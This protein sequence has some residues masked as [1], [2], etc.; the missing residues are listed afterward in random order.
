MLTQKFSS[1][2]QSITISSMIRKVILLLVLMGIGVCSA[3]DVHYYKLTRIQ[4]DGTPNRNVSGGQF[5]TFSGPLCFESNS[6]GLSVGNGS[7]KKNAS[8]SNS[9]YTVYQGSSYWGSSTT[10][11]FNADKSVLNVV[12]DNG[13]IYVYK[14]AT[15]PAGVKTCSLIRKPSS[16]GGS[17]SGGYIPAGGQPPSTYTPQPTPNNNNPGRDNPSPRYVERTYTCTYCHGK[18]TVTDCD[19]SIPDFSGNGKY[20]SEC[21]RHVPMCHIHKRCPSC[22][23]KGTY[24][25][26][27]RAN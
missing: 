3:Q 5:I 21:G 10:F 22:G 8:Y 20:C 2:R 16:N 17:S 7:L 15:P 26:M 25:K 27:E 24:T 12:L 13:D 11:K 4:Q 14:R 19:S 9:Q 23:G 1:R 18:G 6:K